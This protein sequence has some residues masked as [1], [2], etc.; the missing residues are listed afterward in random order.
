MNRLVFSKSSALKLARFQLPRMFS[1][2]TA[3]GHKAVIFDMGGVLLESPVQIFREYE[4]KHRI[5]MNSLASLV[6]EGENSGIF[7]IC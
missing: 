4:E 7:P 6:F 3:L 2:A 5:P 1:Q